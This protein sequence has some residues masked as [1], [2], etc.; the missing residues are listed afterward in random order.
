MPD[1]SLGSTDIRSC[2]RIYASSNPSAGCFY[3]RIFDKG[4]LIFEILNQSI[5]SGVLIYSAIFLIFSL[6]YYYYY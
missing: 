4:V 5:V 6:Y 2:R 1:V 3:Y